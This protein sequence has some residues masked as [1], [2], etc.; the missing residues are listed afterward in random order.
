MA[1]VQN[2]KG[3]VL[4]NG[5]SDEELSTLANFV[6]EKQMAASTPLFLENMQGES[7]YV[8][9]SGLINL[10]KML[11]EGE[12]QALGTI[13]PGEFFG[14]MALVEPGPRPTSAMIAQDTFLLSIKR[15]QFEALMDSSPRVA[16]KVAMGMYRSLSDRVKAASPR[17]QQLLM[18]QG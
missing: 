8:V 13:G 16:V 18:S 4:F 1:N 5:F 17:I 15:S 3:V 10:T 14:E 9:I 12:T 6:D 11:G 7:M 2:L